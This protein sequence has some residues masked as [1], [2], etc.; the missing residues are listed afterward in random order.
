MGRALLYFLLAF[1][2]SSCGHADV[3]S[4]SPGI[5]ILDKKSPVG[6]WEELTARLPKK[7]FYV[8]CWATWCSPCVEEFAY[9]AQLREFFEKHDI[10]IL[11]LNSDMGINEAGW[12]EFIK[13]QHLRGYHVRLNQRLQRSLIDRKVYNPRIPQFMIM[14]SSGVILEKN[15]LRPSDG[16]KLQQ[17]LVQLLGL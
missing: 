3:W 7:A 11:Y 14:D 6:S 1:L 5:Y 8:D 10:E 17:Q 4:L 15:A 16:D 13:E 9:Y 12:F 2:I